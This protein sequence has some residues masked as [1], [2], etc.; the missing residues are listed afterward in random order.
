MRRR[1][2]TLGLRIDG[3]CGGE[4]ASRGAL[5]VQTYTCRACMGCACIAGARR[6]VDACAA[7]HARNQKRAGAAA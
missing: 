7:F 1:R 6:F 5:P 3:R 4:A 2:V